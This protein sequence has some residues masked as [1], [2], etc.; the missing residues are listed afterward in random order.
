MQAKT[1]TC[2]FGECSLSTSA[3]CCD[4][5]VRAAAPADST[6]T[7]GST[8]TA[9]NVAGSQVNRS[10][11]LRCVP[12]ARRCAIRPNNIRAARFRIHRRDDDGR[13]P[14]PGVICATRIKSQKIKQFI[15]ASSAT[16]SKSLS[17]TKCE[18]T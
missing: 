10:A 2:V 16:F 17:R 14:E 13:E 9:L 18:V 5:V 6:F 8:R 15:H 7:I 12:R 4:E 3:W 11:P 1:Y